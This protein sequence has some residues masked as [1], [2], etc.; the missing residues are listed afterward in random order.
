MFIETKFQDSIKRM[1]PIRPD[2]A[3]INA[4]R[5]VFFAAWGECMYTIEKESPTKTEE[6]IAFGLGM[7]RE[8]TLFWEAQNKPKII[9]EP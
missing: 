6:V 3:T 5:F 8:L 7:K 9:L 1:Y 4:L 2:E